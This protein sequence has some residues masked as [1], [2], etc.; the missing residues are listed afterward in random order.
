MLEAD[1]SAIIYEMSSDSYVDRT[2]VGDDPTD[3]AR[4]L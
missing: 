1:E 3:D 4:F 2:V